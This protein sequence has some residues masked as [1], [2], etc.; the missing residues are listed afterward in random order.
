MGVNTA[1]ILPAQGI[2]FAIGINT[3]KLVAAQLIRDGKVRRSYIGV[4]VQTVALQR[5]LAA[6][7]S[8]KQASALLVQGV[9]EG[10]P[11][12]RAGL[13]HDD[14]VVALAGQQLAGIDDL[15]RLLSE[16]LIGQRVDADVIRGVERL[17][18]T[19][20]PEEDRR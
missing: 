16:K 20:V 9:E 5:R 17:N 2:C 3:A 18:L 1:T 15:Q 11:A 10:S 4:M 19:L 13:R 12:Q 14:L 6:Y 7:L 8:L